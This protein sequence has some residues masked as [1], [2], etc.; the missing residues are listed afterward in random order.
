VNVAVPNFRGKAT[1]RLAWINELEDRRALQIEYTT[2]DRSGR[3]RVFSVHVF[4]PTGVHVQGALRRVGDQLVRAGNERGVNFVYF[5][6][7][8]VGYAYTSDLEHDEL[9]RLVA[10]SLRP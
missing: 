5:S 2:R 10:S 3:P 6:R 7:N 1:A 4:D 8:G 9:L